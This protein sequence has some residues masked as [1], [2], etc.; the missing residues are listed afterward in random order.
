MPALHH[1]SK[2]S[3]SPPSS[4]HPRLSFP[5]SFFPVSFPLRFGY[6]YLEQLFVQGS[7]LALSPRS[8]HPA[9]RHQ[10]QLRLAGQ[11]TC[12][13]YRD[14]NDDNGNHRREVWLL[15]CQ[16]RRRAPSRIQVGC[17]CESSPQLLRQRGHPQKQAS[18]TVTTNVAL[19]LGCISP[20][21]E[22]RPAYLRF[23]FSGRV[24]RIHTTELGAFVECY[25][26]GHIPKTQLC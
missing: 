16:G 15:R 18:R 13:N 25:G 19:Q 5:S 22:P 17:L 6:R 7:V 8:S 9:L 24:R 20:V 10:G 4:S 11:E 2:P 23:F 12:S 3:I 1:S 14:D 26:F 21:S